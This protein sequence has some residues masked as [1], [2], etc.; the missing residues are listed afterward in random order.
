MLV[1]D[2]SNAGVA[3]QNLAVKIAKEK[4][5]QIT[6]IGVLDIT[7]IVEP[8]PE[9][10]VGTA[11]SVYGAEEIEVEH[12]H[13]SEALKKFAK[14]CSDAEVA[15]R[16]VE[17]KGSPA[18]IIEDLSHRHDL[19]VIGQTT[20]FHFELEKANDL[21]VK[22]VARDNPRPL[23]V[24]PEHASKG[25][26]ILVAYDGSLQAARSL[27]MFL[28]LGLGLGKA[29]DIVTIHKKVE[30]ATEIAQAAYDICLKHGLKSTVH[31]ID[32]GRSPAEIILEKID[33]FKSG[34]IVMGAFSHPTIREVLFG[35]STLDLIERCPIPL[36]IHH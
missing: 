35:S 13:V 9:P 23:L 1:V 36:F 10:F 15:F 29:V 24:V 11:Y 34:T 22:Q 3:A 6:G 12:R 32:D 19:I 28:L 5:A 8:L 14:K 33:E 25:D 18:R 16:Y 17:E 26:R 30:K 2:G 27:H 21:T 4:K 7:W 20:E 31:A